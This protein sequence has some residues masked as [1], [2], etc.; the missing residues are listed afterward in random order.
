MAKTVTKSKILDLDEEVIEIST[1]IYKTISGGSYSI[2]PRKGLTVTCA[3]GK[4]I[5]MSKETIDTLIVD[6][7]NE[8]PEPLMKARVTGC[9][10]NSLEPGALFMLKDNNNGHNY[11]LLSPI[12]KVNNTYAIDICKSYSDGFHWGNTPSDKIYRIISANEA[13]TKAIPETL[14]NLIRVEEIE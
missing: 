11:P 6:M 3:C 12:M 2:M 13:L 10:Y 8:K 4:S 14:R 7:S 5:N 9:Q 1:N